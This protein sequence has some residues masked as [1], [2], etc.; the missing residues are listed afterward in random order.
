MIQ[1]GMS[2]ISMQETATLDLCVC[3]ILIFLYKHIFCLQEDQTNRADNILKKK[4]K[5]RN[6]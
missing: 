3:V 2:L 1:V 6:T 5:K 4:K